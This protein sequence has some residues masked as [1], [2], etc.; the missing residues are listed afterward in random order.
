ML[1]AHADTVWDELYEKKPASQRLISS[2]NS[3]GQLTLS[4]KNKKYGIGADDRAGCAILWLLRD[5]GH[6]LL[7][8]NG[9]E[10]GQQGANYLK[11]ECPDLFKEINQHHFALQFD[12][13]NASD[14]KV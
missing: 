2:R 1:V 8:L 14:Y 4:G 13:R 6:S 11:N 10:S 3:A 5:T 7:I 12:R 9:E